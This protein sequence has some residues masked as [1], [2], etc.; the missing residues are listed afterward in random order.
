M[1][2]N[3]LATRSAGDTILANFFNDFNTALSVDFVG[4]NS[5]GVPTAGQNLGNLALPW[6][7]IRGQTLILDGNAVDTSQIVSPVNRIVSGKVRTTSNQ[8][9]FLS[10]D[11]S[12][13]TLVVDVTPTPLVLDI[14]GVA[15]SVSGTDLTLT[16]LTAAPGT[17]NTALVN[18]TTAADQA[19]TRLWG[20]PE[21]RKT[22]I[23]DTV[24]AQITGLVGKFAAFKIVGAGTEYFTAFVKSA[25]ELTHCRRGYF[26]DSTLAPINRTVFSNNDVITLMK[27]GFVFVENDGVT[28]DVTYS[29]PTWSAEQPSGPATGDYWYDLANMVWKRYDGAAFQIINRT[30]IGSFINTTAACVGARSGDF[31]AQYRSENSLAI[32][33]QTTEIARSKKQGGTV[34]VAGQMIGFQH[35]LPTWNITTDLAPA[36]DLYNGTEQS[37]TLYYLYLK[38]D[39]TTVISDISPYFR[40][41]FYGEY[42]PHNPWRCVGLASNNSGSDLEGAC[43]FTHNDE[44]T[45]YLTAGNGHGA[46]NTRIRRF[47]NSSIVGALSV[48]TDSS[49]SGMALTVFWP[50]SFSANYID[51]SS[52]GATNIGITLNSTAL[53]LEDSDGAND[54]FR[55]SGSNQVQ[56][57]GASVV[58]TM[59]LKIGDIIRAH[60]SDN[61]PSNM[62]PADS[63]FRITA[64]L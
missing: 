58:A 5:S 14:N 61:V 46:V 16:G 41:D 48:Y 26:V 21:H 59:Q 10:P 27:W 57:G 52:A 22:I 40:E 13:L 28:T 35:S 38:D 34:S 49:N 47:T 42:H 1:G 9:S 63:G 31:Y 8:P 3:S 7:T 6:G 39:G 15:V 56:N 53:T 64:V 43:G 32:D 20:E 23:M 37:S 18:D 60:T 36:A 12:A 45:I 25:T 17:A 19:D 29:M 2:L 33:L 44:H 30:L 62:T 51:G 55:L 4:R 11:G 50:R 54:P 24:G